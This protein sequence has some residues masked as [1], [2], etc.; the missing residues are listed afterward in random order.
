M[1]YN[2]YNNDQSNKTRY[3]IYLIGLIHIYLQR[4]LEK[5]AFI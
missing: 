1:N 4:F 3:L 5:D 2:E